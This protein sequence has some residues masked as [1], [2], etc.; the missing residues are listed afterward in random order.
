MKEE[1]Q[2][3]VSINESAL[4]KECIKL[5]TDYLRFAHRLAEAK[6]DVDE[7]KAALDLTEAECAKSIRSAPE[8]YGLEKDTEKAVAAAVLM[9]PKYQQALKDYQLVKH[10]ADLAQAVVGALECKKRTLTLLVELHGMGYFA[11]PKVS[12][13]GRDAVNNMTKVKIRN[14]LREDGE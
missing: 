12:E 8:K 6:R 2:S 5:P 4:D 3:V 10:T 1:A 13:R 11:N 9:H 7:L 14:R